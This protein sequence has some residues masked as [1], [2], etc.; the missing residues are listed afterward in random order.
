MT[1][2]GPYEDLV[3]EHLV[4][5]I[6]RGSSSFE[7][8]LALI[9][10]C[11]QVACYAGWVCV[12]VPVNDDGPPRTNLLISSGANPTTL[13]CAHTD[14][15]PSGDPELWVT[16][17]GL[18]RNPRVGIGRVW[19][20]G[21]SDNLGSVA[22]LLAMIDKGLLDPS[23]AVALTADE[24]V[25]ALGTRNLARFKGLPD[26]IRR[27]V[28]AI[29]T[30]NRIVRGAKGYIPFD[31]VLSG[32]V[33]TGL[34]GRIPESEIKHLLV[35]GQESHSA[36]P[37]DGRNALFELAHLDEVQELG[38]DIVTELECRGVRNKV[39][40]YAVVR[41][42]RRPS[43]DM[44]GVH[45]EVDIDAVARV[46][47]V[48]DSIREELALTADPRFAPSEVTMNVGS[49][50][51]RGRDIVLAC[52]I[53]T[54]PGFSADVWLT[55]IR[56]SV[57]EITGKATISYPYAPLVPVWTDLEPDV[58]AR[59][60]GMLDHLAKA[61]YTEG[62]VFAESGLPV[63][64]AGPGNLRVHRPNEYV[65]VAALNHGIEVFS[66]LFDLNF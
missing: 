15:V 26:S 61:A 9:E 40:G 4:E 65:D 16:T 59:I 20:L 46:L 55:K 2:S 53:R 44:D 35:I 63:L 13:V 12:R 60:N 51:T 6:K 17:G 30:E 50:T 3:L 1:L 52:D 14:T 19:G 62:A 36:R 47:Q 18:P 8:N 56:A 10:Y 25:G 23:I 21:A 66:S 64:L 39:P 54:L 33:Q 24:E 58:E 32:V 41:H 43:P 7:S 45:A 31:L 38:D 37:S 49:A 34:P 42:G 28:V 48:L 27:V 5:L 22:V 11:E 57:E 29:P